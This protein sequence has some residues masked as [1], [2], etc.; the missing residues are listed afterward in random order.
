MQAFDQLL[1]TLQTLLGPNG[2]EWDRA[3]TLLS[4]R[5]SVLEEACEVIDAINLGDKD[6]IKEELGDLFFN[7]I[8]LS[9]LAE[10]EKVCSLDD[11]IREIDSK[12]IRRH[13]HVF[14]DTQVEGI[15]EVLEQWEEIKTNE[16][17]KEHRKSLLDGIP[18]GL[19]ALVRAQKISKKIRK[20]GSDY[21]LPQSITDEQQI[22]QSLYQLV[23]EAQNKGVDAEQALRATL[24]QIESWYRLQENL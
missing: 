8:F 6:H 10:K 7:V 3:Q 22:G 12:L 23:Q 15:K 14:G 5:D 11:V 24:S 13:P 19:P 17:G 2:C 20:K 18:Q 21:I 9:L 16:K 1:T 4:M